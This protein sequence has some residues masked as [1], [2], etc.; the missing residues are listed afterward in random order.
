MAEE[1]RD[2]YEVLGVSKTASKDEIKAAYRK[3]AK[4]YHPDLNH[5]PDAPKKFEEVQEAYD[6]LYD[7]NKRKQYDQFGMAAFQQG[8]STGGSGNPFAGGGFQGQGF[9]D[10]DLGDIFQ[11]FFGGGA[12]RRSQRSGEARQGEDTLYR[13]KINFMDA[14]NGRHVTFPI[15]Y[16]EPCSNC[17]GTGADTPNDVESCPDCGG[18]GYVRTR[19][20]TIF[21]VM[22][23]EGPCPRCHGT[24]KIVRNRCHVCGGSGYTRVHRDLDVNIPAGIANGQQIRVQGKGQRGINGGA[25]GDLYVEVQVQPHETF[26]REGNDI[27]MDLALSFVQCALGASVDVPTVYGTVSVDVPAGTQPEQILKLRG[28]GVKDL[29]SGRPGDQYLHIKVKTPTNLSDSEKDLLKEFQKQE[30]AKGK[31]WWNKS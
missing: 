23:S 17:H 25:N 27:H 8:A 9:G 30:D 22:E 10:V 19:Q 2:Y 14:I 24:G 1:K 29:R 31:H 20:Q 28:R 12:P 11:S 5:S 13:V 6:V 7:D 18:T 15:T 3:L 4:Q 21:G 26:R 16:D